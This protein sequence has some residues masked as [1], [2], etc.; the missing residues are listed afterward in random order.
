MQKVGPHVA[1]QGKC[2]VAKAQMLETGLF[3]LFI[4]PNFL[5]SQRKFLHGFG[6]PTSWHEEE[7][8]TKPLE[9]L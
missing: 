7:L 1:L 4:Y 2:W 9:A 8:G 3:L 5:F 6:G